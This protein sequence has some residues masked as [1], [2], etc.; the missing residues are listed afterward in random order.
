MLDKV[1]K[2]VAILDI[3]LPE[4]ILSFL[5]ALIEKL[6][7]KECVMK[8]LAKWSHDKEICNLI[9]SMMGVS[10]KFDTLGCKH[11]IV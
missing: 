4:D 7:P 10:V 9:F 3:W 2:T 5:V 8:L 6:L 11:E 1:S